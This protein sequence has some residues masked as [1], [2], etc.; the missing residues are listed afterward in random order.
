MTSQKSICFVHSP[1]VYYEQNYGTRFVPLWAFT[2]AK[3]V[4]ASWDIS[5]NDCTFQDRTDIPEADV[6]AFS[7]INQDYR[8]ICAT[9]E[10]LK[11]KYPK[12]TFILGGPIA[13]SFEN[14]GKIHDLERFDHI[15]VL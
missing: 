5:I 7:A 6:F 3:Y 8:A 2:L 10:F 13:W 12:S 11:N 9:Q 1:E 14:D 15:F 4:P